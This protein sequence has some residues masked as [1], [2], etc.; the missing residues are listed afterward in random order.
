MARAQVD[1]LRRH[2]A[3]PT[4]SKVKKRRLF[5]AMELTDARDQ[6][7]MTRQVLQAFGF[8]LGDLRARPARLEQ[9]VD[10]NVGPDYLSKYR[11]FKYRE[12]LFER[13][14]RQC[15]INRV[16]ESRGSALVP[17]VHVAVLPGYMSQ[18]KRIY[19][20]VAAKLP[21]LLLLGVFILMGHFRRPSAADPSSVEKVAFARRV[22]PALSFRPWAFTG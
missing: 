17:V 13:F 12:T 20:S 9:L 16:D 14:A 4:V 5:F 10:A 6:R 2:A 11:E 7:A 22:R 3:V 18:P 8:S 19:I 15:E 21:S 1:D